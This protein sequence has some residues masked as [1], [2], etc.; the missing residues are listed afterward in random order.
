MK[1]SF[2]IVAI[3]LVCF[4]CAPETLAR[5]RGDTKPLQ[6]G[7]ST[8][9]VDPTA[10][11]SL[12]IESG[13][14]TVRGSDRA[15]VRV[16]SSDNA[17]IDVRRSDAKGTQS[18]PTRV[19]VLMSDPDDNRV[20]SIGECR[21]SSDVR[22]DVPRGATVYLT[23]RDGDLDVFD[24]AE[25]HAKS[26]SGNIILSRISKVTE[27]N[28]VSGDVSLE[29][30]GG[31]VRLR[32]ESGN[33][34]ASDVKT[35]ETNDF[36]IANTTSGDVSLM[37]LNHPNVEASSTSGNVTMTGALAR[38][39]HYELGSMS[40]NVT[41][42]M[43]E[44]VSFQV[45]AKVAPN[46]GEIVTDFPIKTSEFSQ[47]RLVGT[48]GKADASSYATLNVSVFSGTLRLRKKQM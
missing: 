39:G 34:E 17:R 13:S 35:V 9:Q 44:T 2:L 11:V 48:Y 5:R 3:L 21:G 18:A 29:N 42:V 20:M 30:S 22:L 43:P 23:T 10:T 26:L 45:I 1:S 31:R 40:G 15:E 7:D 16:H 33:I 28:S 41:L 14:I 19:D 46:S 37:R 12:C 8:V 27:A 32:S 38:G 6:R 25:V 36:I 4:A 24:V 47:S